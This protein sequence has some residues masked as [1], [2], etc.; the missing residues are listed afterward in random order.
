MLE[1]KTD[2]KQRKGLLIQDNDKYNAKKYRFVARITNTRVICQ[3]IYATHKGD[4]VLAQAQSTEL[5]KL[6]L[7]A[8]LTNYPTAYCTGLLL[9]RRLLK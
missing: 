6:G 7:T 8:G 2:Y 4:I 9:A 1:G 3:V 5:R